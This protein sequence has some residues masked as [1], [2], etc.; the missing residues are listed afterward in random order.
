MHERFRFKNKNELILKAKE[1]GIDLPFSDDIS[2]LLESVS[3]EGFSVSNRLVVQPM[4]GYDS[5]DDGSPSDLTR[6]RYLRYADGGSGIIWYEAVSVSSGGRSN[7]HQLW[8][9]NTNSGKYALLN[10]DLRQAA[11]KLGFNPFLVIQ[12]THSGRYSK[13]QGKPQPLVA[14]PNPVLD[15]TNPYILTDD[16][17]KK[18]QDQY[19]EAARLAALSGFD[20]IDLKACHGYLVVELLSAK[21]RGNSVYGGKEPEQRFRFMLETVERIRSEVPQIIITTR[22]NISDCYSGGFGVDGNSQPDFA[23]PVL[24]VNELVKKGIRLINISMGSPYYNPY[25]TRP[26]DTPLPGHPVPEEHPLKSVMRM[27]KGTSLFQKKFPRIFFVGSA[28]SYL[29]QYAPNVGAAVVKNGDAS[30][31]G[32]GRGSFAYPSLP[33]DLI[34]TGQAD[35]SKVCITCSGCTRLIKNL[36]PGGCVIR[37]RDIYGTE[38][39]KLIADGK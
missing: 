36:R 32:F 12:L 34:K 4:E 9:N 23:E 39:K 5:E 26:F 3:V 33:V 20:A 30:F 21:S 35:P 29:R 19:V 22:L 1:L 27:I 14:A 7:P 17:L 8:L 13:P 31:I 15:K 11:N 25:V 24:L 18:I 2:P 10:N 6:R 28:Y 38:L 37:D 16:D